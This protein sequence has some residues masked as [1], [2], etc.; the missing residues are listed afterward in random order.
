MMSAKDKNEQSKTGWQ[1]DAEVVLGLSDLKGQIEDYCGPY[2]GLD[3]TRDKGGLSL[4]NVQHVV[5]KLLLS[6]GYFVDVREVDE[7]TNHVQ[8]IVRWDDDAIEL[9][10]RVCATQEDIDE[11]L[12]LGW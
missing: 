12:G 10:E 3:V 9:M 6:C 5:R 8:I 11:Y 1:K 2:F 4:L 7:R